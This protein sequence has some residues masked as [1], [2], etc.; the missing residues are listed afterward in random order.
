MSELIKLHDLYFQPF[1][2]AE[3]IRAQVDKMGRQISQKYRGQNPIFLGVLNG[4]FVFAADLIRACAI[5]CDISFIKLSSYRGTQSSGEVATLIGLDVAVKNRPVIIIEDIIDS[6]KTL[7]TF[8]PELQQLEPSSIE[9]AAMLTKPEALEYP[10]DIHYS[11]FAIPDKF[12]VGYGLDYDG[13]GRNLPGIYQ[14][15]A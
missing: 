7:Y 3:A 15:K 1:I 4:A 12:V 10:V 11:G 9:L 2:S 14:H 5:D 8:L 6:G 13:L